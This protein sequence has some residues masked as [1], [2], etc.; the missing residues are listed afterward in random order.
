M[1][2]IIGCDVTDCAY[3]KHNSCH[4]LAITVGGPEA[5]P[6]CDT[7]VS[8][9]QSAGIIDMIAGVGACKVSTCS[10]NESLECNADSITVGQH[11]NH[12]DCITFKAR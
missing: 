4:T 11:Q 9:N 8:G 5:C 10:F 2:T 12:P 3:N 1:T 6:Q 7:F